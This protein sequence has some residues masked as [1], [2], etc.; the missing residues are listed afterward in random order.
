MNERRNERTKR[1]RKERKKRRKNEKWNAP[2][3][4]AIIDNALRIHH[5]WTRGGNY[6]KGEM[7]MSCADTLGRVTV[8]DLRNAGKK[9]REKVRAPLPPVPGRACCVAAP[10]GLFHFLTLYFLSGR[11]VESDLGPVL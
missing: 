9:F 3:K 11:G 8:F 6:G 5:A 7:V 2:S 4:V 1:G 10:V